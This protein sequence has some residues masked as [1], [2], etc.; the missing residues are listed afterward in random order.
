MRFK[1]LIIFVAVGSLL[2]LYSV[3]LLSQ[4]ILI[5]LSSVPKYNG[6][7]VAIQGIVIDYRTTASGSQLI[8]LRDPQ[9]S[10]NTVTLY[11][12][13]ELQVEFGDTIQ[14]TGEV[15]QYKNNWE[16][17]INDPQMI[18]ILQKWHSFSIPLWQLALHPENYRD[19]TVNV[20]GIATQSSGSSFTLTSTDGTYSID[21][22]YRSTCPH[23]FT[24]GDIVS[25]GARFLYDATTYRFYL[26]AT[27]DTHGIWRSEG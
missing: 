15:Q 11:I 12:E 6:Q 23:Q 10:T 16:L 27:E 20:T 9:N 4:P 3:S 18:T 8:T 24:K 17:V 13:G 2:A 14:A 26:K 5:P 19:T 1:Y 7:H 22:T 21:V 25:V